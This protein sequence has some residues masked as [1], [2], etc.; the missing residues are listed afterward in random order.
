MP[1]AR[2]LRGMMASVLDCDHRLCD[3]VSVAAV[4]VSERHDR[5]M[6]STRTDC[7]QPHVASTFAYQEP[8]LVFLLGTDTRFTDGVGAAD[9][10]RSGSCHFALIDPRSER[11]FV[12]RA[13]SIGLRY[14]LRPARRRLQYQHREAGIADRLPF[15]G[16]PMSV[17]QRI[18]SRGKRGGVGAC[19][20]AQPMS[21]TALV[22]L[23][24]PARASCAAVAARAS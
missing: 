3:H 7:E 17:S 15:A 13:E 22:L 9:F 5:R 16:G 18:Q 21:W 10:L 14:S 6:K 4:T 11:S 1:N 2:L 8:S 12:Q 23:S 24:R 19:G 20:A